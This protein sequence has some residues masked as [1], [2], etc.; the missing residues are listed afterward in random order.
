MKL[1]DA[2][3]KLSALMMFFEAYGKDL[4]NRVRD[5]LRKVVSAAKHRY[6]AASPED[7]ADEL[8]EVLQKV[9]LAKPPVLSKQQYD[10]VAEVW[11]ALGDDLGSVESLA[12]RA[13]MRLSE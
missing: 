5:M 1:V 6:S 2:V 7:L 8:E 4:E 9:S 3:A 10:A 13:L 12:G 11:E